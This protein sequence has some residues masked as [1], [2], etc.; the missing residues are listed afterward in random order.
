MNTATATISVPK[1]PL[2]DRMGSS[3]VWL[4]VVGLLIWSW[5]PTEMSNASA[6]VTDWR[7]MAE[8]ASAFL[9]P[10]FH[11]WDIY[12][13]EMIVTVQIALWGTALAVVVGIPF[14]NFKLVKYCSAMGRAT[15]SPIDGC[16]SR[17]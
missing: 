2:R 10:N 11:D 8:F 14:A 15:D 17:H 1:P 12:I 5:A 16:F 6:L 4:A 9:S 7:N 3:L 13:E